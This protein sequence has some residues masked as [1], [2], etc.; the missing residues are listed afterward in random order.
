MVLRSLSY[1]LFLMNV[2]INYR[3]TRPYSSTQNGMIECHHQ[4]VIDAGL[5]MLFQFGVPFSY[6]PCTFKSVV[7]SLNRVL[8]IVLNMSLP[9][10][11]LYK[12]TTL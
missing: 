3:W 4:R 7:L 1:W 10:E 6:W 12:T 8:S 9:Y 11:L 2:W 5:S